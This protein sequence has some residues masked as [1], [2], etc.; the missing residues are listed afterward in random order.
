VIAHIVAAILALLPVGEA[1]ARKVA[2]DI[3]SAGPSD[4]EARALV[5]IARFESDFRASVETCRIVGAAGEVSIFQITPASARDR[6]NL[7]HDPAYA[8]RRALARWRTCAEGAEREGAFACYIGC[9]TA[10]RRVRQRVAAMAELDAL[11]AGIEPASA[12]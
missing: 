6:W 2:R 9:T 5:V 10:D 12:P 4:L 8:A 1:R 11:P 7:C 3:A